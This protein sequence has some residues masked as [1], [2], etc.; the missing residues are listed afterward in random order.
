MKFK[1]LNIFSSVKWLVDKALYVERVT[2]S[3]TALLKA[4]ENFNNELLKIW[5]KSTEPQPSSFQTPVTF[6]N[7]TEKVLDEI[8]QEFNEASKDKENG[9]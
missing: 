2:R 1:A 6:E 8:N 7:V 5:G 9:E 4:L 3:V